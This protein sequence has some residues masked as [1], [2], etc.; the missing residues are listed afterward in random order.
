MSHG[1][2]LALSSMVMD[3]SW[4]MR[5][6]GMKRQRYIFKIWKYWSKACLQGNKMPHPFAY[7]FVTKRNVSIVS[8]ANFVNSLSTW[9]PFKYYEERPSSPLHFSSVILQQVEQTR[10]K[11]NKPQ[12]HN[13]QK[14]KKK[15]INTKTSS[16]FSDKNLTNLLSL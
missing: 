5:W 9:P 11:W 4:V 8:I 3:T 1:C 2:I 15:H 6:W 16:S 13:R 7:N 12:P 10:Q 14:K